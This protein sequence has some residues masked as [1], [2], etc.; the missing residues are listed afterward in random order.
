MTAIFF[1][2]VCVYQ[3]Q[4]QGINGI[5]VIVFGNEVPIWRVIFFFVFDLMLTFAF[6]SHRKK[7]VLKLDRRL[8][9]Y[10]GLFAGLLTTFQLT[11]FFMDGIEAYEKMCNKLTWG[12]CSASLLMLF[13]ISLAYDTRR[14]E[15]H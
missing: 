2:I 12:I 3:F 11:G 1:I 14:M 4:P 13:L 9:F 8:Y 15:I 7:C 10:A 6:F 5:V